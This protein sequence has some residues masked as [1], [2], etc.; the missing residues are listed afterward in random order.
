MEDQ[1]TIDSYNLLTAIQEARRVLLRGK[2]EGNAAIDA[3]LTRAR[4]YLEIE[5]L[6]LTDA[7]LADTGGVLSPEL[8]AGVHNG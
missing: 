4:A 5:E 8:D 1:M 3:K 7:V 2:F 6:A